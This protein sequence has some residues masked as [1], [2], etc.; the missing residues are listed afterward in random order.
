MNISNILQLNHLNLKLGEHQVLNDISL[1]LASGEFIILLGSNGSGKSSLLKVIYR[2]YNV[3]KDCITMMG[4][5]LA[6]RSSCDFY[7]Q[8]ALLNQNYNH[9]LF[10]DLTIRENFKL[11][12]NNY[13]L[14]IEREF[15]QDLKRYNE[16]F[17][18]MGDLAQTKVAKL[19]GGQKQTLALLLLITRKPKLIL[20][21]EHTSAL[22]QNAEKSLMQLTHQIIKEHHISCIMVTHNLD[23]ATQYG[24][25]IMIMKDGQISALLDK[26][27][28]LTHKQ[29]FLDYF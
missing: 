28:T 8:V 14:E 18:V 11:F 27:D 7:N 20:L 4:K 21:D 15:I 3:A 16:K 9:M 12:S 25:K 10:N 26:Q 13:N 17:N 1:E 6:K 5:P 24:D 2:E 22:D 23:I 19:S 29:L